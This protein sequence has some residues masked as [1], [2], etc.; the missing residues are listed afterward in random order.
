[1]RVA[2]QVL[3]RD[4]KRLLHNPVALVVVLGIIILPSCYAWYCIAS[5]WNPYDNTAGIKVAVVNNDK[6]VDAEGLGT[7]DVGSQVEDMLRQ[8]DDF[9]WEFVDEGEA[10]E[11][12]DA[13]YYYAAIVI[14]SSFSKDFVSVLSGKTKHPTVQYYV[15]EK[16]SAIAAK[17]TD[18]GAKTIEEQINSTFV[19]TMSEAVTK[20]AKQ[21]V[22]DVDASATQARSGVSA[23]VEKAKGKLESARKSLKGAESSVGDWHQAVRDAD[24]VMAEIDSDL[25]A[26]QQSLSD[27]ESDLKKARKSAR[28]LNNAYLRAISQ[29]AVDLTDAA[30][31]SSRAMSRSASTLEKAQGT[32]GQVASQLDAIVKRNNRI[33]SSLESLNRSELDDSITR[34]KRE[35]NQLSKTAENLESASTK[36]GSTGSDLHH[37]SDAASKVATT[38]SDNLLANATALSNEVEP[39]VSSALDTYALVI[40]NLSGT[41]DSLDPQVKQIRK[42]LS[43]MDGTLAQTKD[44][45]A[46]TRAS[47]KDAE[48]GLDGAVTDLDSIVSALRLGQLSSFEHV[49]AADVGSFMSE[50]V[51]LE[52]QTV[53]PVSNYGSA[54]APFYTNL[55]LWIGCFMLIAVI[56]AETDREG[57]PD[58][59]ANQAFLG[60]YLLM[61]L[62]A[63]LQAMVMLAGEIAMGIQCTQPALFLLA[64]A[65]ISWAYI[66]IVYSLAITFKHVGKALAVILLIFQIP[67]SSGMYPVEMM[68]RF[69]Q[70]LHPLLPFTYGI[71]ALREVIGGMYGSNYLADLGFLLLIVI[72][73]GL[74]F[75]LVLRRYLL[76]INLL[77]DNRLRQTDVMDSEVHGMSHSRYGVRNVIQALLNSDEYR[78]T[79]LA[80]ASRFDRAYPHLKRLGVVAVAILPILMIVV[81][82]LFHVE[83]I[84]TKIIMLCAVL[85]VIII[86]D[87]I[88]I[89]IEYMHDN[90]RYQLHI[91]E[92]DDS[93]LVD[94]MYRH[95]PM[96]KMRAGGMQE[97]GATGWRSRSQAFRERIAS[98]VE[99]LRIDLNAPDGQRQATDGSDVGGDT[100]TAS[101]S[102][103]EH[104]S[105][106]G[107]SEDGSLE[108][109]GD[110]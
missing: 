110:R 95:V 87:C 40:G 72:P 12:L 49:D 11:K 15:N 27:A 28:S 55:A 32:T 65:V 62:L 47:L 31:A 56:R 102:S 6:A 4:L 99:S 59:T 30:N 42:L 44:T 20:A 84:N 46:S 66:T 25:P 2:L 104:N 35:N 92:L 81:M 41:I 68:P 24:G 1:M 29:T 90:L 108:G 82:S 36:L 70:H 19:S 83:N 64:G 74:F 10:R 54:V 93:K 37:A 100:G 88:L 97:Q 77:F 75:G 86:V 43:Q 98:T 69:F 52:T 101:Q 23:K 34:L 39:A 57:F 78:Q 58:L 60:R 67:G 96:G 91:T 38:G 80:R 107:D 3:K 18:T 21:A 16:F 105:A 73:V 89:F 17:V 71:S 5:N 9:T 26:L 94:A 109:R 63:V 103:P 33:I 76:N 14:P 22:G 79:L 7:V 50:P 106:K 48:D 51:A 61:T 8:N 53:Y 45:L 85:L 13:G